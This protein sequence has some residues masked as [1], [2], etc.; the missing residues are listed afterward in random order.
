MLNQTN[1]TKATMYSSKYCIDCEYRFV[2][3]KPTAKT[4]MQSKQ[5][6]R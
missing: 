1:G 3:K 5:T 2:K 6:I 4:W